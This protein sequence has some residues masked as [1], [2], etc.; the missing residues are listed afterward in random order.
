MEI[1]NITTVVKTVFLSAMSFLKVVVFVLLVAGSKS[2]GTQHVVLS[3][4]SGST[5]QKGEPGPPGKR[6]P[7]GG[8]GLLGPVGPKG[9]QGHCDPTCRSE[10]NVLSEKV[11]RLE[12][13]M[14]VYSLPTSCKQALLMGR[15]ESGIYEIYNRGNRQSLEVYCDQTTD[16][17]G[18]LVFQRRTD[19]SENFYR[20]WAEY[21]QKFGNL[22]NEFWLG[23]E[24]LHSLTS[25]GLYELRVDLKDCADVWKYAK[26]SSFS[27]APE[28]LL[29]RLTVSGYSGTAG[30]SLSYHNNRPFTTKD[31]DNDSSGT[32]CA[33]LEH[34]AW[35]YGD[36]FYSNLNGAYLNCQTST[37]QAASWD[38]FHGTK[39][40]LE[41]IEMKFRPV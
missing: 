8:N 28:E 38:G 27:I 15:N 7:V 13:L 19:G 14:E 36:C 37:D 33:V 5:E 30:D 6:G 29:Y 3:C 9:E 11:Q 24:N 39:Y 40:S 18:W 25:S 4:G 16:G 22:S 2:Q 21:R 10:Y 12:R 26:F 35:W 23:M 17:G 20:T 34:G 32:N 1:S 31:Q 41:Y